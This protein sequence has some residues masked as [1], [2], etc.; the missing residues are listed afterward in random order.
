MY[1]VTLKALKGA[2]PALLNMPAVELRPPFA[3]RH[4]SYRS[5]PPWPSR[6]STGEVVF[7]KESFYLVIAE[8]LL[9]KTMR[10]SN[11]LIARS[12][13]PSRASRLH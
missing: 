8:V 1:V 2:E 5:S 11:N 9:N 6:D 7:N 10:I 4:F 12:R 3:A 13:G